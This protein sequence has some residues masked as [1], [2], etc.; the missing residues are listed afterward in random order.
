MMILLVRIVKRIR[1]R[2]HI[3]KTKETLSK[4]NDDTS[5]KDCQKNQSKKTE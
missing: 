3:K 1:V 2:R 4:K 5:S